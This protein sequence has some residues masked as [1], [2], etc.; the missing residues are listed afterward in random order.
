MRKRNKKRK[1]NEDNSFD[2]TF[3]DSFFDNSFISFLDEDNEIIRNEDN[4]SIDVFNM[5]DNGLDSSDKE[6]D[7]STRIEF[8]YYDRDNNNE[9]LID[10][11]EISDE[12]SPEFDQAE[13]ADA[14]DYFKNLN[15]D[16]ESF[17]QYVDSKDPEKE[18][19]KYMI[20]K[21]KQAT[22]YS[23]I[24]EELQFWGAKVPHNLTARK[25]VK[26]FQ[27]T[28]FSFQ[29]SLVLEVCPCQL[30]V[31]MF[32]KAMLKVCDKCSKSRDLA[33][34]LHYVSIRSLLACI[35]SNDDLM[36][37]I[38]E[39][40]KS[41]DN[42]LLNSFVDGDL[43]H[44]YNT[45]VADSI[46]SFRFN[47][48]FSADGCN[49]YNK[50]HKSIN[51]QLLTILDLPDHLRMKSDFSFIP[52]FYES[53]SSNRGYNS[54]MLRV[55]MLDLRDL[56]L[57]GFEFTKNNTKI[58][59][60]INL[61]AVTGDGPALASFYEAKYAGATHPCLFCKNGKPKG[62]TCQ[63]VKS[64]VENPPAYTTMEELLKIYDEKDYGNS[65]GTWQIKGD[66]A[67]MHI[68]EKDMVEVG[69]PDATHVLYENLFRVRIGSVF[70]HPDFLGLRSN[71]RT[72]F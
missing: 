8:S 28:W 30:T 40:R 68:R 2:C 33:E 64:F 55:L 26:L 67:L 14:G 43:Y 11:E 52:L 6:E 5:E 46:D 60:Y 31:Y 18:I 41:R 72:L 66:S 25:C 48:C 24:D 29:T 17:T 15:F 59:I 54:E 13:E 36:D 53:S 57:N 20:S 71:D 47:L 39:K 69:F 22:S 10:V 16:Y 38:L 21:I 9:N 19:L 1:L 32:Q 12:E 7:F 34:K 37:E 58:R 45:G 35:I 56:M 44:K 49:D 27:K 23:K 65:P 3:D 51:A 61:V 4:I 62:S 70:N 50:R 63:Y 42:H